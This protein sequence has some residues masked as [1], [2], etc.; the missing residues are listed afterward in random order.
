[1]I[2]FQR[3]TP[4]PGCPRCARRGSWLSFVSVRMNTVDCA[5][6]CT[7]LRGRWVAERDRERE[8]PHHGRQAEQ[9]PLGVAPV[10]R[11]DGKLLKAGDHT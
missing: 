3:S 11:L 6:R 10:E 5:E 7:C 1:M 2:K 4:P 9:R 8:Q